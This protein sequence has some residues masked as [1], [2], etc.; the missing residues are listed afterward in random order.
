MHAE[1]SALLPPDVYTILDSSTGIEANAS[2]KQHKTCH[3]T[4]LAIALDCTTAAG[5]AAFTHQTS[6]TLTEGSLFDPAKRGIAMAGVGR[7]ATDSCGTLLTF[8]DTI[9]C[10]NYLHALREQWTTM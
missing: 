4:D 3:A 2:T 6:L 9:G 7:S 5:S 8:A 1:L 10:D